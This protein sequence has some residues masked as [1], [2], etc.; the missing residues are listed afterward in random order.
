MRRLSY[1]AVMVAVVDQSEL[2]E[3]CLHPGDV[4]VGRLCDVIQ[5][6]NNGQYVSVVHREPCASHTT[7]LATNAT[8]YYCARCVAQTPRTS[9]WQCYACYRNRA[10]LYLMWSEI[11]WARLIRRSEWFASETFNGE[12][13]KKIPGPVADP[14]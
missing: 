11:R 4:Q 13:C 14:G 8:P 12:C 1:G 5:R 2:F 9:R 7:L 6:L 3:C 10:G